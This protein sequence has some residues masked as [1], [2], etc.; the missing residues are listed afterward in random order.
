MRLINHGL[1][2]QELASGSK[3]AVYPQ[4]D[5]LV[6]AHTTAGE[7]QLGGNAERYEMRAVFIHRA[8]LASQDSGIGIL[9]ASCPY[10]TVVSAKSNQQG[11]TIIDHLWTPSG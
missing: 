6:C 5:R 4:R 1:R 3:A 7:L 8:P 10:P 11:E 2:P 9:S